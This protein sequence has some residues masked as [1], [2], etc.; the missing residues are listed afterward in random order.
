MSAA[1]AQDEV[2][3]ELPAR[4]PLDQNWRKLLNY[5]LLLALVLI[6]VALTNMPVNLNRRLLIE[7]IFS[8]GYLS[9]LWLPAIFGFLICRE[10]VLAGMPSHAK[11]SRDVLAGSLVGLIGGAGLSILTFLLDNFN[12]RDPLVNWSPQLLELLSFQRDT[13]FGVGIWL[14]IGLVLGTVGGLGHVLS[15]TTRRV[16]GWAFASVI[17]FAIFE[18]VILDLSEGFA[19][20]GAEWLADE[21]YFIRG[22]LTMHGAAVL[23]V[24]GGLFAAFGRD[25]TRRAKENFQALEGTSR[26]RANAIGLLV[27]ATAL[28]ILPLF[29]GGITN[30]LLANVGL[31]VLLALGLNIVVGLAGIL[32]L[33]YV[34]F[35]AVGGYTAGILTT[36][37]RGESWPDWIPQFYWGTALIV[38]VILAALT[39]LFIGAPVIR[40]RGDYL[41]IVTLG[42]GEIIRLLFLSDWLGGLHR[43]RARGHQHSRC[44]GLRLG[45]GKGNRSA[46]RVL[47]GAVLL[48]YRHIRFVAIRTQSAGP[49]LDGDPRRRVGCR[50]DGNQHGQRQT[51]GFCGGRGVG[52]IFGCHPRRQSGLGLP[53]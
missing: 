41:A 37:N 38:V 32:D 15:E 8:M 42:F 26:T 13:V 28:V 52:L 12:L 34:A 40:M 3:E 45:H 51:H 22:G 9:L 20:L 25:R 43:C 44:A 23:A 36:T 4:R 48:R 49:R 39:G 16:L 50:S 53:Q 11:G 19:W 6:F 5:G 31:F 47:P 1:F 27:V 21:L 17:G 29:L 18:T 7:P 14:P 35:F 24:V 46:G 30:E 2:A 33:G 10:S